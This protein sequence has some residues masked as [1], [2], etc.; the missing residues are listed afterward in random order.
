MLGHRLHLALPSMLSLLEWGAFAMYWKSAS[1]EATPAAVSEP[2]H[3]RLLHL[4]LLNLAFAFAVAPIPWA[5]LKS[6]AGYEWLS[7]IG[8]ALQS[9]SVVLAVWARYHLAAQWSGEITIKVDHL[10]VQTG[11]YRLIRHPIY[12]ALL[13]MLLGNALVCG[14]V[15]AFAG[16]VIAI[17][18]YVRKVRLEERSLLYAFGPAYEGFNTRQVP[19]QQANQS[20]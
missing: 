4:F 8:L 15:L 1:K 5:S 16:F 11:P 20:R 18:A 10:L 7:W 14:R 2:I 13:G 17:L 12:T 9:A 3:S 6:Q 19:F